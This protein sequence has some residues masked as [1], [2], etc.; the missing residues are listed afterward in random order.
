[1]SCAFELQSNISMNLLL[2]T[3]TASVRQDYKLSRG[4]EVFS[5]PVAAQYAAKSECNYTAQ[6]LVIMQ[7]FDD[8]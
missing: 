4:S 5:L 2:R 7:L 1:M 6:E 8:D 3:I